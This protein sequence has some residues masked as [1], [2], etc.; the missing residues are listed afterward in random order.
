M[1][2]APFDSSDVI[3]A[4]F[5]DAG[6][7]T[8]EVVALLASLVYS[9]S[10]RG[11]VADYGQCRHSIAASKIINSSIAGAPF[12]TTPDMFDTQ[13]YLEELLRSRGFHG[14]ALQRGQA[15]SPIEG[16]M[17]IMSDYLIAR[18]EYF[19]KPGSVTCAYV[20]TRLAHLLHLAIFHQ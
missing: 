14:D 13:F 4:R 5:A 6:F 11:R 1:V 17:R 2:P 19:F 7:N 8:D 20:S 10:H 15:D 18:G 16:E 3:F 12:D 9:L